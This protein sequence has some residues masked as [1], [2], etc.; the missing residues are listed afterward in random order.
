[1]CHTELVVLSISI[2][3]TYII[4]YLHVSI[5]T[6]LPAPCCPSLLMVESHMT[7]PQ[8]WPLTAVTLGMDPLTLV[9]EHVRVTISG[10]EQQSLVNVWRDK[11]C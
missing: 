11:M 9:T 3:V 1:M 6:Q 8:M 2:D 5:H 10:V 4:A 7:Q